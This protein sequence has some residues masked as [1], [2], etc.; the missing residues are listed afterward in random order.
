M[1]TRVLIK[2][3]FL[4]K[5]KRSFVRMTILRS[6]FVSFYSCTYGINK[7][8]HKKN[9]DSVIYRITSRVPFF[10]EFVISNIDEGKIQIN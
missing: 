3:L 6:F 8:P 5:Q 1:K 7:I 10:A 9:F 2:I 4:K